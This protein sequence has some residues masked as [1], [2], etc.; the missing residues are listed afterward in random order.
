[1]RMIPFLSSEIYTLFES[2]TIQKVQM[3]VCVYKYY[4]V[5]KYNPWLSVSIFQLN[6][7]VECIQTI[8]GKYQVESRVYHNLLN[9]PYLGGILQCILIF[10]I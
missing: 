1:M 7:W 3:N 5:F 6:S 8:R 9:L 10:P 4:S 2:R